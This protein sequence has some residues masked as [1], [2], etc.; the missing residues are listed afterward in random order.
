[1]KILKCILVT[2]LLISCSTEDASTLQKND[3]V[4]S[5]YIEGE[6][7]ETGAVI[8]CAGNDILNPDTLEIYFYPESDTSNYKLFETNSSEVDPNDF[9][10]YTLITLS[11]VPFFNG[12]LRKFVGSFASERWFIV[13]FE[14][15]NEIKISNPIRAKNNSQPTL[16]SNQIDINQEEPLMPLFSWDVNS[17]AD[18]AIFFQVLSTVNDD[19]ISGTYTF[20]TQFQYYNTSNVVLNITNGTPPDLM[21]G[22]DY[23]FTIMDVSE[24]NWVNEVFISQF[25]LQ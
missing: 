14:V 15:N 4:L 21:L 11:D 1:M 18:N 2:F 20:E 5:A 17:E 7:F 22:Q 10:N 23:K 19:L 12:Y 8:A 25:T 3:S 13:T 24:D 9:S 16:F 6:I